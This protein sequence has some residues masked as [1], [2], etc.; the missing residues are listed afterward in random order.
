MR[1]SHINGLTYR[2]LS[3]QQFASASGL[4]YGT[5]AEP[6]LNFERKKL[7]GHFGNVGI[8]GYGKTPKVYFL[9]E[10]GYR[11]LFVQIVPLL[12]LCNCLVK[13]IEIP[14]LL[15]LEKPLFRIPVIQKLMA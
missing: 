1:V 8:R 15:L 6:L 10:R 12:R 14:L 9:T 2:F 11:L 3:T 4:Q 13:E 7:L 5:A